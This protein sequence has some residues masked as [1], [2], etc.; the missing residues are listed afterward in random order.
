MKP[1][2][3]VRHKYSGDLYKFVTES[4]GENQ[5]VKYYY[6]GKIS[7]TA[8]IDDNQRMIIH[9]DEAIQIASL[10]ANISDSDGNPVLDDTVWQVSNIAPVLNAF[11]TID[12]YRLRATRFQGQL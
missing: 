12:S 3:Y 9:T 6:V 8:G 5:E 10:I 4:I 7:L 2:G 11:N 1:M